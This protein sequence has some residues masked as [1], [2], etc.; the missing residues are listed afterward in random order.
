MGWDR[1]DDPSGDGPVAFEALE[2]FFR[3]WRLED[4]E[5]MVTL[6]DTDQMNRWT[7]L[8]SPFTHEAALAYVGAAHDARAAGTTQLAITLTRDGPPVG[9]VIV[10]PAVEPDE[11]ELA[12]AVGAQHQGMGVG[13][14]AVLAALEFAQSRGAQRA[15]LMIADGNG[16]SAAVARA[17]GF[18]K[19][20]TPLLERQRKGFVLHLKTWTRDL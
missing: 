5:V 8:A 16:A 9:E 1:L 18:T 6:F 14:R 10:F 13:R 15:V 20:A 19:S 2:L 11:V 17:A 4:T 7:P 3:A 12:Y